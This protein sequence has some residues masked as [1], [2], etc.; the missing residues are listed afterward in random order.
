MIANYQQY[1]TDALIQEV[2]QLVSMLPR[3]LTPNH[4]F[5]LVSAVTGRLKD[6]QYKVDNLENNG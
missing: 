1:K 5:L 2:N 6:L 3:A 4:T